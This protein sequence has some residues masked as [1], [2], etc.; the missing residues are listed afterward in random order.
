MVLLM[1][2]NSLRPNDKKYIKDFIV[3]GNYGAKFHPE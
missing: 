3:I 1:I 2:L